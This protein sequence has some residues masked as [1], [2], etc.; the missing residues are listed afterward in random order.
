YP[1]GHPL[2]NK[3]NVAAITKSNDD[4]GNT[5]NDIKDED[6]WAF[7]SQLDGSLSKQDW[8]IDSAA[9]DH[10]CNNKAWFTDFQSIPVRNITIGDN[11]VIHA[12]GRGNVPV[13][14]KLND[15]LQEG[16]IKQ[17]VYV[18]V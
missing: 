6:L 7:T 2:H 1:V 16:G 12:V 10:Y 11:R 15:R 9:S 14:V 5:N 4:G 3:S 13:K 17:A 18:P 8:V